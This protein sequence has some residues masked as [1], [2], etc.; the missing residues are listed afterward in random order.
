M[1]D[2]LPTITKGSDLDADFLGFIREH[3]TPSFVALPDQY[4]TKSKSYDFVCN[5]RAFFGTPEEV[6]GGIKE[7][8]ANGVDYYVCDFSFGGNDHSKVMR[9]M[10][11][12][13]KGVMPHFS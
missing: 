6:T 1:V 3:P 7:L 12:F 11:L 8:Q 5:N 2:F 13:A 4:S 9:S 10:E